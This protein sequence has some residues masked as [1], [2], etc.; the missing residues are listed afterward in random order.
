MT[1]EILEM[2]LYE[3]KQENIIFIAWG[4]F[5]YKKLENINLDKH[6]MLTSSHPSPLS[7]NKKFKEFPTFMESNVFSKINK[8]LESQ[9][10]TVINW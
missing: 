7:C 9:N 8:I 10:Q 4:A 2:M 1:L 6:I 3:N 5:A